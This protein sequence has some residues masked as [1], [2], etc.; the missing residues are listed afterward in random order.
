MDNSS[1][2]ND[3]EKIVDFCDKVEPILH[4]GKVVHEMPCRGAEMLC[5]CFKHSSYIVHG[6]WFWEKPEKVKKTK[7][8]KTQN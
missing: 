2:K 7:T 3:L 5:P 1:E 4:K 6:K 8:N